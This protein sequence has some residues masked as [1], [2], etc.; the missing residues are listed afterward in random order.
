MDKTKENKTQWHTLYRK[1]HFSFKDT[2]TF[3]VKGR[4]KIS[5]VSEN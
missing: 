4:K 5:Y 3:E 1:S 2:H